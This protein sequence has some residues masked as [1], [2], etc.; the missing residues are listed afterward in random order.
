MTT[1]NREE[2]LHLL[3]SVQPG[4]SGRE[5]I[6]QS[7]CFVFKDG[8]VL[9]YNDEVACSQKSMLNITGAVQSAPLLAILRKLVEDEIDVDVVEGELVIQGKRR[10]AGIRCEETVLLPVENVETPSKWVT[11]H[12]EFLESVNMVQHCAGHDESEFALTCVHLMPNCIEASDNFQIT[13]VKIETGVK[14]STLVRRDSIK[15]IVSMGMVE[16]SETASWLHF[17]NPN[18]LIL[19]CRRYVET[20]PDLKAMLVFDAS[21]FTLPKGLSE[22][23]EKA[24]IFSADSSEDNQVKVDLLPGK[25]RLRGEGT[26]G[27]F[28]ERRKVDYEGKPISFLVSPTLLVDLVA[29]HNAVEISAT[30]LRVNGGRWKYAASLNMPD[31][32]GLDK[33]ISE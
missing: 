26:S 31:E 16:L 20:Y 4:L 30:R 33:E 28:E 29:K 22:A 11:L 1:V 3:E 25:L 7:S 17:R 12:E 32:K 14:E 13:R 5:I 18:G 6:E 10:R 15:H 19:S 24:A 2:F 9:T 27:W 8:K 23:A 21:P